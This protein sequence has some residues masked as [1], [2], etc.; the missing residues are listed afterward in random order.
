LKTRGGRFAWAADAGALEH[1]PEHRAKLSYALARA[2]S[3]GQSPSQLCLRRGDGLGLAKWM[4]VGAA[5][6]LIYGM[7]SLVLIVLLNRRWIGMADRAARGL[8]KLLWFNEFHFYGK[9]AAKRTSA[10]DRSASRDG[11]ASFTAS[12][13]NVTQMK[14]L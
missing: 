7:A 3:Y 5:Q 12:A 10:R 13:T 8:G 1:A 9:G 14:S 2:V 4:I 6:A 11:A